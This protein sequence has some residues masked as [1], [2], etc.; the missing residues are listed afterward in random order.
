VPAHAAL[1]RRIFRAYVDHRLGSAAISTLLND[2]GQLTSRRCQ[3]M[4]NRVLGVLRNPIY[5]G[6][7][8]NGERYQASHEPII[9]RKLFE[10][11]Q[12]LLQERSES[13]RAQAANASE[14]LLTSFLRCQRCGHRFVGTAAHGHGCVY[15]Y[16]T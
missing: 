5:I 2:A 8:P 3:W 12:L 1:V 4:P 11:A 10:R 9:D 6:Q 16:Y 13:P 15:R 14:Y 7:L